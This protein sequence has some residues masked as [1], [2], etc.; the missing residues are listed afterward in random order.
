MTPA[1]SVL[2]VPRIVNQA[3]DLLDREGFERF[4]MRRLGH[5]LGVD[6]MAIYHHLP[7]KAA[8][9][10]AVVDA[11]WGMAAES[12]AAEAP[13]SD[14][15]RALAAVPMRGLRRILLEHPRLVPVLAT[16]PAVTPALLGLTDE[17]VGRLAS[18]GL[19][20]ASAMPLLD[21]LVG[22]TVGK[23]QGEL[24]EPVGGTD[25]APED[26]Y[27]AVLAER[28]PHLAAAFAAGYDWAPEEQFERGLAAL[29]AGWAA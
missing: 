9:F 17:L 29:L 6:P 22:F 13:A 16:R 25:V 5:E 26:T 28:F 3:I 20:P 18:A 2:S 11:L 23:V 14:D 12:V 4:S 1:P 21:C 7:N 15:W 19:P 24:R 27:A 10:D 8:L